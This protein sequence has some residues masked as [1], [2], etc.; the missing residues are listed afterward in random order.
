MEEEN[1]LP[2]GATSF[3]P[4]DLDI[5]AQLFPDESD[6]D[7]KDPRN[8]ASKEVN[9]FGT[10]NIA[11]DE[12]LFPVNPSLAS[13]VASDNIQPTD[14]E[15]NLMLGATGDLEDDGQDARNLQ[16]SMQTKQSLATQDD[17]YINERTQKFEDVQEALNKIQTEVKVYDYKMTLE[18]QKMQVPVTASN[19]NEIYQALDAYEQASIEE[20][21]VGL[22]MY[23]TQDTTETENLLMQMSNN[24]GI[25]D[26]TS[27][28]TLNVMGNYNIATDGYF[29]PDGK[30]PEI[31]WNPTDKEL[32]VAGETKY[33]W[34]NLKDL[35]PED[36]D[37]IKLDPAFEAYAIS[38]MLEGQGE[39]ANMR[40]VF[41]Q[42]GMDDYA[43]FMTWAAESFKRIKLADPTLAGWRKV[44]QSKVDQ[45][46]Y[47]GKRLEFEKQF[48]EPCAEENGG[49]ATEDCLLRHQEAASAWWNARYNKLYNDNEYIQ[50]NDRQYAIGF[51]KLMN[52]LREPYFRTKIDVYRELDNQFEQ[53]GMTFTNFAKDA[54][55][56]VGFS[57]DQTKGL[58][59]MMYTNSGV[60]GTTA[61]N[62]LIQNYNSPGFQEFAEESGIYD[63]AIKTFRGGGGAE[64]GFG[65][66]G[67]LQGNLLN[68]SNTFNIV[69]NKITKSTLGTPEQGDFYYSDKVPGGVEYVLHGGSGNLADREGTIKLDKDNFLEYFDLP[70]DFN[71]RDLNKVGARAAWEMVKQHGQAY[72]SP[73][74]VQEFSQAKKVINGIDKWVVAGKAKNWFNQSA[75]ARMYGGTGWRYGDMT[76]RDVFEGRD[77]TEEEQMV[78]SVL[79]YDIEQTGVLL[80]KTAEMLEAEQ[81]A[82]F[83]LDPDV[84]FDDLTSLIRHIIGQGDTM[85]PMYLGGILQGTGKV[86]SKVPGYGKAVGYH[87]G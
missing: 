65:E 3:T 44:I 72:Y 13:I 14:E 51:S 85:V 53:D 38:K 31:N 79:D 75:V 4:L 8:P 83:A 11:I 41:Q 32:T 17:A 45:E 73:I 62:E 26:F 7:E 15:G 28:N 12:I 69:G 71:V 54:M 2:E 49:V 86:V 50:A 43:T 30:I 80:N 27:A 67:Y 9:V 36:I 33:N 58:I 29:N 48:I 22:G 61:R 56:K 21:G 10:G 70:E 25:L 18:N 87:D 57:M 55:A 64:T 78:S 19:F 5:D 1:I 42:E 66:G 60:T 63:Q 20:T 6:D 59:S 74:K 46:W 16:L 35:S 24:A 37:K 84:E 77:A 39:G 47:G 23:S 40:D 76:I 52:K 68:L 81:A 82:G 34:D